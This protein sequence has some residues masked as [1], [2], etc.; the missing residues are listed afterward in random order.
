MPTSPSGCLCDRRHSDET[1]RQ[2]SGRY[3]NHSARDR[4]RHQ[5]P[6]SRVDPSP[7]QP[8]TSMPGAAVAVMTHDAFSMVVPRVVGSSGWIG[9]IGLHHRRDQEP[10]EN[11]APGWLHP[12]NAWCRRSGWWA[13]LHLGEWRPGQVESGTGWS[14]ELIVRVPRSGPRRDRPP[15]RATRRQPARPALVD[16]DRLVFDRFAQHLRCG[17][18]ELRPR[19]G[20]V[21]ADLV[22]LAVGRRR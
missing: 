1:C 21:S 18:G 17:L 22:H 14:G 6:S 2:P 19:P 16:G 5:N 7:P 13:G 11:T 20:C 9:M 12:G 8:S 15:V 10:P 4:R 3:V